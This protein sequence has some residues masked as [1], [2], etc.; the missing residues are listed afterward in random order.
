MQ[1]KQWYNVVEDKEYERKEDNSNEQD[2]S[3]RVCSK[4][5]RA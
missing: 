5:N 4:R 3:Y 2:R 1:Q